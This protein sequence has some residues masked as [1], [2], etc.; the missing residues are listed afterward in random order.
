MATGAIFS[1]FPAEVLNGV[2]SHLDGISAARLWFTGN[3]AVN[4]KLLHRGLT[5]LDITLGVRRTV[6]E[7]PVFATQFPEL[8]YLSLRNANEEVG[9]TLD[10]PLM[11]FPKALETLRLEVDVSP[12]SFATSPFGRFVYL[13]L[14]KLL[15]NLRHLWIM[16]P[17]TLYPELA[18]VLPP[19]LSI[20]LHSKLQLDGDFVSLL[21]TTITDFDMDTSGHETSFLQLRS[22]VVPVRFPKFE[23][24]TRLAWLQDVDQLLSLP[25]T[26]T[27]LILTT[28]PRP[29]AN[30]NKWLEES[31]VWCSLPPGLKRLEFDLGTC[32]DDVNYA[33]MLNY[34]PRQL[35]S[36][37]FT[38][39]VWST[40]HWTGAM[41][42][43]LPPTLTLLSVTGSIS[44][45]QFHL[46]PPLLKLFRCA[47]AIGLLGHH[48][49]HLPKNLTHLETQQGII[50]DPISN[51]GVPNSLLYLKVSTLAIAQAQRLPPNITTLTTEFLTGTEPALKSLNQ[52]I[53]LLHFHSLQRLD[54]GVTR[55]YPL[56]SM[57]PSTLVKLSLHIKHDAPS[58][59]WSKYLP[60]NLQ[61][62]NI[63]CV[64]TLFTDDWQ[65]Q[66]PPCLKK[67]RIELR[68]LPNPRS[69]TPLPMTSFA[70]LPQEIRILSISSSIPL[71]FSPFEKLPPALERFELSSRV[72]D[73]VTLFD[74]PMID[75]LPPTLGFIRMLYDEDLDTKFTRFM[76]ERFRII[77][78]WERHRSRLRT[79]S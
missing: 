60:R 77:L 11:Q 72:E 30:S 67:L 48:L 43:S 50:E 58:S 37:T 36:L 4:Y 17:M 9:R 62:M 34:F 28:M 20:H 3:T 1:S 35:T 46:L 56:V 32:M 12:R 14:R 10:L 29:T 53:S 45:E 66:L 7:F 13:D 51:T 27:D 61:K 42:E 78:T 57:L 71:H 5:R 25:P 59:D 19:L 22:E 65:R 38:M 54:I 41:L 21:P 70:F 68:T 52:H 24:L 76:A 39:N 73:K 74:R 2:T 31:V 63:Y 8:R 47:S 33:A 40:F 6:F 16:K 75:K 55:P 79:M 26:I 18:H 15:P 44:S 49:Q 69:D 64:Y 23:S